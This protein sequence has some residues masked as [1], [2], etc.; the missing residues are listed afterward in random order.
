[1]TSSLHLPA[2]RRIAVLL[3]STTSTAEDLLPWAR[4][5][6]G[7]RRLPLTLL[8]V[9]DPARVGVPIEVARAIAGDYL[10]LVASGLRRLPN[11]PEINIEV[12]EGL[13]HEEWKESAEEHPG[14]LLVAGDIYEPGGSRS[15]RFS[16]LDGLLG[17]CTTPMVVVPSRSP[18]PRALQR[19]VVGTG[20]GELS[21][22]VFEYVRRETAASVTVTEVEAVERGYLPDHQLVSVQP[23]ISEERVSLRGKAGPLLL[24]VARQRDAQIIVVGAQQ[25]GAIRTL[26]VGSTSQW[27]ARNSDRPVVIVPQVWVAEATTA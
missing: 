11:A 24:A 17:N 23:V 12:R 19:L 9:I 10:A 20:G 1:M 8:H 3:D 4:L 22:A 2:T 26:L 5:L 15:L 14:S 25:K 13:V 6:D 16:P 18:V 27:L 21:E 7:G